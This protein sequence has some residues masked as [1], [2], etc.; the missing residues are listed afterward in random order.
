M[1]DPDNDS[2]G[3]SPRESRQVNRIR[4]GNTEAFEALF[5]AHEPLVHSV[6]LSIVG[7]PDVARDLTQDLF[8]ELWDRRQRFNPTT[9]LK[10]Y[11]A[12]A[13][14]NK[15]LSYVQQNRSQESLDDWNAAHG[16]GRAK[17][18]AEPRSR[19]TPQDALQHRD[20]QQALHQAVQ[21]LPDRRR[22]IYI[23][24]RREHMS[25]AEIATALD[26]AVSTVKTQMSRALK[27][28][29]KRLKMYDFASQT[30]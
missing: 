14:R 1:P 19:A 10:A 20:L 17:R 4:R 29:R 11:L 16:R 25:Y 5:R 26:I 8:C 7:V 15:A 12:G 23:M 22:L 6:C 30:N 2:D 13:A 18:R 3:L 27:F 24:A 21:E 9:S 28:L